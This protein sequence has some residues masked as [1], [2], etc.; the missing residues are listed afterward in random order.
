MENIYTSEDTF[1]KMKRQVMEWKKIFE[2]YISDKV[3]PTI[4]CII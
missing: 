2:K 1:K 3:L 4:I